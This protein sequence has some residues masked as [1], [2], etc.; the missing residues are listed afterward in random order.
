[1]ECLPRLKRPAGNSVRIAQCAR[2]D[3]SY[4]DFVNGLNMMIQ[5]RQATQE[6]SQDR[7]GY[8]EDQRW[9]QGEEEVVGLSFLFHWLGWNM[10]IKA[11]IFV[12]LFSACSGAQREAI[13]YVMSRSNW[14]CKG[15]NLTYSK[16]KIFFREHEISHFLIRHTFS[17][18]HVIR[19]LSRWLSQKTQYPYPD[20]SLKPSYPSINDPS[21]TQMKKSQ[22]LPYHPLPMPDPDLIQYTY[23]HHT[24][25]DH[26]TPLQ[27]IPHI[28]IIKSNSYNILLINHQNPQV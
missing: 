11:F 3:C 22:T 5:Y 24:I 2:S 14:T 8:G 10:C 16:P 17:H 21:R 12:C 18:L 27:N 28:D 13:S 25:P 20:R 26:I 4:K 1:M 6:Q 19:C 7:E 23:E 15:T 9:C